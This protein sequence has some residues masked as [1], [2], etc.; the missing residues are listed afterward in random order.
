MTLVIA[1]LK[2]IQMMTLFKQLRNE[3]RH[4][5]TYLCY[6]RTTKVQVS[7]HIRAI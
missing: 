1:F 3:S 7:L 6:M 2:V 4:E 5:K